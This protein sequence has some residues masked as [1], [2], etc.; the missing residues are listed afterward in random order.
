MNWNR[1]RIRVLLLT[2]ILFLPFLGLWESSASSAALVSGTSFALILQHDHLS[3]AIDNLPLRVVL[4]K[5]S[6]LTNIEVFLEKSVGDEMVTVEFKNLPLE[7][8]IRR[9]LQG[10]S[11]ALAYAQSSFSRGPKASPKVVGIRVVPKSTGPDTVQENTDSETI[12]FGGF[13][14]NEPDGQRNIEQEQAHESLAADDT[15]DRVAA[16]SALTEGAEEKKAE[17]DQA[18][19]AGLKDENADVREAALFVL[20]NG[21]GPVPLE[22]LSQVAMNDG[23]PQHRMA[24]LMLLAERNGQEAQGPLKQALKD[25]DPEVREMAQTLLVSVSVDSQ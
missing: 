2:G 9:I 23:R 1:V 8:G 6:R 22:P 17:A 25:P 12:H 24:A 5:L 7:K 18:I 16:L 20:E 3:A 10:N 15:K 4:E 19:V 14:E 13:G 21:D 11:Y